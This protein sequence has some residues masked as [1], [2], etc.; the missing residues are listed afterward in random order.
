MIPT[1][2]TGLLNSAFVYVNAASADIRKT[3]AKSRGEWDEPDMADR[4][5]ADKRNTGHEKLMAHVALK[6]KTRAAYFSAR[7]MAVK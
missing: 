5:I 7:S 3:F 2:P 4:Q 6:R 1:L